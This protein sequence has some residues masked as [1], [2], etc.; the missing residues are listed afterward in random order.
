[1]RLALRISIL[2]E[3]IGKAN[4]KKPSSS[5]DERKLLLIEE[6]GRTEE[7]LTQAIAGIKI[8]S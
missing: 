3:G 4:T 1:M 8:G 2:P 7:E 5:T 6:S